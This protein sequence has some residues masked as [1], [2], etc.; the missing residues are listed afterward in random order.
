MGTPICASGR[1]VWVEIGPERA[2]REKGEVRG[3]NEKARLIKEEERGMNNK[4]IKMNEEER[5]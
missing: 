3:R 2:P 5:G 1:G 4:E